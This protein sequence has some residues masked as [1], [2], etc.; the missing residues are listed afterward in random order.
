MSSSSSR[1]SSPRAALTPVFFARKP[2]RLA[3]RLGLLSVVVALALAVWV[4]V[5]RLSSGSGAVAGWASIVV[6]TLF[7]GGVQ[8]LSIGVLGEYIGSI[9]DE[10]KKRPDYVVAETLNLAPPGDRAGGDAPG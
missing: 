7:L 2:L 8:L 3:V 5:I 10:T 1:I 4:L 6:V 9:F